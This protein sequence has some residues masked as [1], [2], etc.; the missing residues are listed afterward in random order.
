MLDVKSATGHGQ[1]DARRRA[2]PRGADD[3]PRR[4]RAAP[5]SASP[6]WTSRSGAA[7][8]N[9][10]EI[11]EV[12]RRS[13]AR[14]TGPQRSRARRLRS[15]LAL[16]DL[17]VD[18]AEGRER[19]EQA[20]ADG[21]ARD[22]L[23]ALDPCRREAI[24]ISMRCLAR[25]RP[26]GPSSSKRRRNQASRADDRYR[27]P[28]ARW[29]RRTKEDEI[30]HAVGVVCSAKRPDGGGGPGARRRA[31]PRRGSA[32]RAGHAVLETYEIGDEAPPV[33]GILLEVVE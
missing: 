7:V 13:S 22:D 15:L 30:D 6:T 12:A 14:A 18:V 24:P 21:S 2:H 31:C 23:R 16:S 27:E 11:R 4:A 19:A 32:A 20:M 5:S 3:R 25:V 28:R 1:E 10:L 9:A 33:R 29:G 8:G 26:R 17:G